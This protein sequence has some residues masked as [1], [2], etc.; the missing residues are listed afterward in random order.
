MSEYIERGALKD[1]ILKFRICGYTWVYCNGDCSNCH[2]GEFKT[3][4]R[5][6]VQMDGGADNG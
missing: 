2:R 3:S 5:T 4:N 1:H 6:E